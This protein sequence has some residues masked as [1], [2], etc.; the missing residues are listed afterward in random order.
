[1]KI[2]FAYEKV[3]TKTRFEKDFVV[4]SQSG[5]V[6]L[7]GHATLDVLHMSNIH[8]ISYCIKYCCILFHD[9]LVIFVIHYHI[10]R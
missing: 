3:S 2:D 5:V 8:F 6:R 9:T 7:E 10:F 1:M 4:F